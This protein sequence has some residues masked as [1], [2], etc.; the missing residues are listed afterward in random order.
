MN[1]LFPLTH[2]PSGMF[3]VG[4]KK[5]THLLEIV[6]ARIFLFLV[7]LSFV[8]RPDNKKGG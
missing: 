4:K 6:N 2:V 1:P 8:N 3:A 7:L 5:I